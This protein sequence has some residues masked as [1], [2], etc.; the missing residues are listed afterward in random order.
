MLAK[1]T[2][3]VCRRLGA[4]VFDKCQTQKFVLSEAHH[5]KF[6]KRAKR[7]VSDF[8]KQLFEK[9]RVR[10]SY[11]LSER[12]LRRYVEDANR[13]SVLGID[14]VV[15]MVEELEMRLD[16]V[17]Y[18]AGLARSRRAARQLVSHGHMLVNGVRSTI[19]SM[20]IK[21]G[22]T[23][24]VRARTLSRPISEHLKAQIAEATS[25]V[26]ITVD[27]QKFAGSV[28]ARPKPENTEMPGSV[29]AILEYYSR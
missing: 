15:R 3:K 11:G 20:Q 8:A 28:T 17:V 22:D 14:P 24:E 21:E 16:N 23:F 27:S 7:N 29:S 2:Y 1:Q 26:W 13:V 18:R 4:G 6:A 10:F 25:P 12:Q 9:Q 5:A 19:P